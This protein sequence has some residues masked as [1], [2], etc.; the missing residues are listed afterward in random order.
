MMLDHTMTASL[1]HSLP[2]TIGGHPVVDAEKVRPAA[3]VQQDMEATD[4][5]TLHVRGSVE[6]RP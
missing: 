3:G 4:T 1:H 2:L 6:N 5:L